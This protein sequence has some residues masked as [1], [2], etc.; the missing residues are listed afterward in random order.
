MAHVHGAAMSQVL[1]THRHTGAEHDLAIP[2]LLMIIDLFRA[3][4]EAL[5]CLLQW[6]GEACKPKGLLGPQQTDPVSGL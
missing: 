1:T 4:W 3:V 5:N 2:L 6:L